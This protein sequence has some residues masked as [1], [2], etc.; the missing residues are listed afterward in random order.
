MTSSHPFSPWWSLTRKGQAL[1]LLQPEKLPVPAFLHYFFNSWCRVWAYCF[2]HFL[3]WLHCFILSH[4]PNTICNEYVD[5]LFSRVHKG[6]I[7]SSVTEFW[8]LRALVWVSVFRNP[9]WWNLGRW[10]HG[11]GKGIWVEWKMTKSKRRG[12]GV[13]PMGLRPVKTRRGTRETVPLR[14]CFWAQMRSSAWLTTCQAA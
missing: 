2:C 5:S 3:H 11:G 14:L 8:P 1:N 4:S 10:F 7:E 13:W 6:Q 9:F 12:D